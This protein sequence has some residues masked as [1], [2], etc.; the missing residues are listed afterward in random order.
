MIQN[1]H[2]LGLSCTHRPFAS[3]ANAHT[4]IKRDI[5]KLYLGTYGATHTISCN[6]IIAFWP[7][8]AEIQEKQRQ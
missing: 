3:P 5:D 1:L 7:Y 2:V 6:Y 8:F 4:P